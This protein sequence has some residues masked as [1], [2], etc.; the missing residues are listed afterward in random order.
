MNTDENL[1]AN[2][3]PRMTDAWY[4]FYTSKHSNEKHEQHCNGEHCDVVANAASFKYVIL[5]P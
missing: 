3:T 4:D 1:D 5:S 2:F